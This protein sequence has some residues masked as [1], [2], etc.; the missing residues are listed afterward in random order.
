MR[1]PSLFP[2]H[3]FALLLALSP[4]GI[5]ANPSLKQPGLHTRATELSAGVT[6]KKAAEPAAPRGKSYCEASRP[7]YAKT[8]LVSRL[9]NPS[10]RHDNHQGLIGLEQALPRRLGRELTSRGA[11]I[12]FRELNRELGQG[13]ANAE[14]LR[15]AAMQAETQLVLSGQVVNTSGP[16]H[17]RSWVAASRDGLIAGLGLN[18]DWDSRQRH[19]VLALRLH[20]GVTGGLLWHQIY[21]AQGVWRADQAPASGQF[22]S[23]AFRKSHYGG[24]VEALLEEALRDLSEVIRCQPLM[25]WLNERGPGT[26]PLLALGRQQGLNAGDEL[27]VYRLRQEP[28]PHRYRRYRFMPVDTGYRVR[29]RDLQAQHSRVEWVSPGAHPGRYLVITSGAHTEPQASEGELASD[30]D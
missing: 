20:D 16:D 28:I 15:R 19:F 5:Q 3:G 23:P 10:A 2:A 29:V 27:K 8:L 11:L 18:P 9:A 13:Q 12:L 26:E 22:Q 17:D 24:E 6:D 21:R 14:P 25:G 4:C 1:L 30:E 7:Q